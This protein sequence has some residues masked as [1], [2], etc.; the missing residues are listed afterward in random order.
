MLKEFII[1]D[2]AKA[3]TRKIKPKPRP[4]TDQ[5][6]PKPHTEDLPVE[7]TG[8]FLSMSINDVNVYS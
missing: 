1:Y 4:M 5:N 7:E 8:A 2:A 6:D 3:I